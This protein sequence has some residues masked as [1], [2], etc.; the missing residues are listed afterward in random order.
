L[1]A[2]ELCGGRSALIHH[3]SYD[4]YESFAKYSQTARRKAGEQTKLFNKA[5]ILM[6]VGPLLRDA[7]IDRTDEENVSM[8]VPGLAEISVKKC[9][10]E[11]FQYL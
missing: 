9:P 4:S 7:L 11:I 3:M 1:A 2:S 10:R 8:L 6:V 5:D